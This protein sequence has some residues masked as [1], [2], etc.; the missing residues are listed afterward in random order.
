MLL[1]WGEIAWKFDSLISRM[2]KIQQSSIASILAWALAANLPVAA[3]TLYD[4]GDPAAHEQLMLELVNRARANPGAEAARLGISLNQGLADGTIVDSPKPP[5][6]SNRHLIISARGH[7]Q[8]MIDSDVFSHTGSGGSSWGTRMQNAGYVF[9]GSWTRGEN[10][11]FKG[12]LGTVEFDSFSRDAHDGLF[13]SPSHRT[14]ICNGS[15]DELG[16]GLLTGVFVKDGTPYNSLL[17]TQNFAASGSTPGPMVLGVAYYDFDGD[18]FYDVGEKISGIDVNVSGASFRAVT[19]SAGGYAFPIPSGAATRTITFLG[20]GLNLSRSVDFPGTINKKEDL[21]LTY[22]APTMTGSATVSTGIASPRTISQ[23]PGADQYQ[24]K[25]F[26][27]TAAATDAAESTARVDVQTSWAYNVMNSAVKDTGS[28]AYRL[29]HNEVGSE[30]L[31]YKKAFLPSV[32][33]QISFRSRLNLATSDQI[34]TLEVS[35]NGGNSWVT[36]FSQAGGNETS[37]TTR[38]ASLAAY[39]GKSIL[40]RFRYSFTTGSYFPGT[41][42]ERG[43]HIDNVSF[44]NVQELSEIQSPFIAPG[45]P[46]SFVASAD[47]TYWMNAR[48]MNNGIFWPAGPLVSVTASAAVSANFASWASRWE[49]SLGL[50]AGTL[51]PSGQ[52]AG[53]GIPNLLKYATGRAPNAPASQISPVASIGSFSGNDH[54]VL[55]YRRLIGTGS[56]SAE[57]GYTVEDVTYRVETSSNLSLGSWQTGA[58]HLVQTS[59]TPNSD[60][61]ETVTVRMLAPIADRQFVRLRVDLN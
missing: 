58:A 51:T 48:P 10:I 34:A 50:A 57:N 59:L 13:R 9:S 4:S 16:L 21:R 60:G 31:M 23:V 55:S 18:L 36:L 40:L 43:W 22:I 37:F 41:D 24:A 53:D 19:A 5:L 30:S 3:Q 11:G 35:E 29:A 1:A 44:T 52:Y 8:W 25:V 33:G 14:N 28:F 38:S 2:K 15:Y 46:F 26:S 54:L 17:T 49:S 27:A 20:P 47:G 12:T 7:S 61:T 56:G 39:S 45:Q 42:N 32:A 6:A